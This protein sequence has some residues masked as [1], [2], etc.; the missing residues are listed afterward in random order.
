[1]IDINELYF[2]I[3]YGLK[4]RFSEDI[5]LK[6]DSNSSH[7]I[8]FS[9]TNDEQEKYF[10]LYSYEDLVSDE[11]ILKNID[12]KVIKMHA[13]LGSS[14]KRFDLIKEFRSSD[15][16]SAKGVDLFIEYNNKMEPIAKIQHEI[17][18]NLSNRKIY[19][20]AK[21]QNLVNDETKMEVL[22]IE[23]DYNCYDQIE[24]R[25]MPTIG[26]DGELTTKRVAPC[27]HGFI[28]FAQIYDALYSDKNEISCIGNGEDLNSTIDT[29]ISSLVIKQNIPIL[30]ITT[31]KTVADKKGGMLAL[32]D[33]EFKTLT[34]CEKAQAQG[35][36][37]LEYFENL[38]L[39]PG[40]KKSLFN[41]N[42]VV[43][44]KKALRDVILKHIPDINIEEFFKN[45]AP[46][47]IKNIKEQ[48]GK[49]YIQLESALGSVILNANT[50]FIK[51]Y[52]EKL[53]SILNLNEKDRALFFLPIKKREDY[54]E[55]RKN[56]YFCEKRQKLMRR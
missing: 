42:I 29:K 43:I 37:Q 52:N 50:Y 23:Q 9:I 10:D 34:I 54:D 15:T 16:L 33:D 3:L 2:N 38:G 24:Q 13:G 35:S 31:N 17:V 26:E 4:D 11:S 49:K 25:K 47:L 51:K 40:D 28:G 1:M 22:K 39:R 30:M 44:N 56:F 27:G 46:D 32:V 5:L 8:P 41:T 14:V 18:V 20:S 6:D 45:I 12:F 21:I 19:K 55:I 7:I 48:E 36:G 53:I